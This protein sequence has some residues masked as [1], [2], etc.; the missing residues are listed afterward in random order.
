MVI[1]VILLGSIS[2]VFGLLALALAAFRRR[3]W[4]L[5]HLW[6]PHTLPPATPERLAADRK[7]FWHGVLLLIV[8]GFIAYGTLVVWALSQV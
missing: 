6:Y 1:S 2:A 4:A 7:A 3:W 5:I 8:A